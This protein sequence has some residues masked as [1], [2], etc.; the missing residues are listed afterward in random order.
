MDRQQAID[1]MAHNTPY[2]V[3]YVSGEIERYI[4]WPSQATSY[5]VGMMKI[6]ELRE[7]ARAELGD[8]FDIRGYHDVVLTRG[9]MPLAILEERVKTWVSEQ[10]L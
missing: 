9:Q 10:K 3:D 5:K 4:V 8:K 2:T 7:W 1:Y 6:L